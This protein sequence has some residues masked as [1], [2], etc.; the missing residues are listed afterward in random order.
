MG[1][2]S[3]VARVAGVLLCAGLLAAGP[4]AGQ[5]PSGG[6]VQP[7]AVPSGPSAP[8]VTAFRASGT[9]LYGTRAVVS[10]RIVPAERTGVVI[11]RLQGDTW[12]PLAATSSDAGGRFRAELPLRRSATIRA[13]AALAGSEAGP[14]RNITVRRRAAVTVSTHEYESI[15]GLPFTVTGTIVPARDGETAVIEGSLDGRAYVPLARLRVRGGRVAGAVTPTKGGMWR[16]RVSARGDRA[17]GAHALSRP[18]PPRRVFAANPHGVP[19]SAPVYLVQKISEMH[20]Y[21]YES[22]QLKRVLPVVFGKPS[23]PTPTGNF[24]VYS[25]TA[26]PGP[27]FGPLAIWYHGNYGIHG[28]NQEHLLDNPWRYYSKGCTRN[29]NRNIYWLWDRVPVGTPVRNLR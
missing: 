24:R 13:R 29:Y 5:E 1:G 23:T 10:G 14:R 15:A 17:P 16:F 8:A 2:V 7:E 22:G 12:R 18:T 21:Y 27:A 4:A 28:T 25:K 20:L 11:E 9:V 26:G 3:C 6:S 19:R